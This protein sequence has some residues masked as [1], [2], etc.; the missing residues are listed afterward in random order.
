MRVSNVSFEVYSCNGANFCSYLS[1]CFIFPKRFNLLG[2]TIL[3]FLFFFFFFRGGGVANLLLY[4]GLCTACQRCGLMMWISLYLNLN[5]WSM[6]VMFL[7]S[8][9]GLSWY[10]RVSLILAVF[11]LSFLSISLSFFHTRSLSHFLSRL[12]LPIPHLFP[13]SSLSCLI[14]PC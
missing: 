8:L 14:S 12:A 4:T 6:I 13:L 7:C 11:T 3:G 5:T 9:C 2:T 10:L 1:Y